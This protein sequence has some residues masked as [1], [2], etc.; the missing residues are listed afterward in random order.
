MSAELGY[1]DGLTC[2]LGVADLDRSIAWYRET[3]GFELIYK[4]EETG[5]CE[6]TTPVKGVSV[7]LS[8]VERPGGPGGATLTFGVKDIDAARQRLEERGIRFDGPTR[9]IEGLTKLATFFDPDDNSLM[10]Y[11]ELSTAPED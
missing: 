4:V 2:S 5:W 11:E 7:G 1:D 6:L 9:T 3:L 10:L 8:Q